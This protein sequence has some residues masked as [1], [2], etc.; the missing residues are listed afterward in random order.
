M[1]D[2]SGKEVQNEDMEAGK[3]DN[4]N[5]GGNFNGNENT[6]SSQN[7]ITANEKTIVGQQ[8]RLFIDVS[9]CNNPASSASILPTSSPF[10]TYNPPSTPMKPSPSSSKSSSAT[11]AS[12]EKKRV[13]IVDDHGTVEMSSSSRRSPSLDFMN[14]NTQTSSSSSKPRDVGRPPLFDHKIQPVVRGIVPINFVPSYYA[15]LSALPEPLLQQILSFLQ[16]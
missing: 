4:D 7:I 1:E 6:R 5:N 11:S 16:D 8:P 9:A 13:T 12:A 14:T 15:R 10:M 2:W 3:I